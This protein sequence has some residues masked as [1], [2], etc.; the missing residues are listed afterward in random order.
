MTS[1]SVAFIAAFA[2]VINTEIGV[3]GLRVSLGL[4]ALIVLL[5]RNKNLDVIKT[6]LYAGI[7]VFLMRILIGAFYKQMP[8]DN[9]LNYGLEI[10]FYVVYGFCYK[11]SMSISDMNKG[12]TAFMQFILCDLAANSAEYFSRFLF[13]KSS[14]VQGDALSILLVAILRTSLIFGLSF[15]YNRVKCNNKEKLA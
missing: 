13:M 1:I 2:S 4:V 3:S 8:A 14:V 6:S 12:L 10:V 9:F 7:G 5:S 11:L 15:L